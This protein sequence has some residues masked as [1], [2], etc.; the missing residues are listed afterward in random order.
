MIVASRHSGPVPS[1]QVI[2]YVVVVVSAGVVTDPPAGGLPNKVERIH[3]EP[4]P[5]I[6]H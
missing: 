5:V 3:D 2:L 6:V 4:P 1:S